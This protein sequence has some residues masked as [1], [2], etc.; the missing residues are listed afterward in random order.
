MQRDYNQLLQ[1]QRNKSAFSNINDLE[2]GRLQIPKLTV[3][4]PLDVGVKRKVKH[5]FSAMDAISIRTG[6]FLRRYPLAR[7]FVFYYM[8]TM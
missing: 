7:I 2:E 1:C 5:T 4:S 8:V 3:V 6:V